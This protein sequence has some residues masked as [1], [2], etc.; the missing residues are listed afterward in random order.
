MTLQGCSPGFSILSTKE[1]LGYGKSAGQQ[2]VEGDVSRRQ[3]PVHHEEQHVNLKHLRMLTGLQEC[4]QEQEL[5]EAPDLPGTACALCITRLLNTAHDARA[6][7][8]QPSP[9]ELG[10]TVLEPCPAC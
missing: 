10:T 1:P 2:R 3:G 6:A 4:L 8:R 9:D 5:R 7:A